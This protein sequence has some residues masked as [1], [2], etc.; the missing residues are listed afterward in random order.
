MLKYGVGIDKVETFVCES[1]QIAVGRMVQIGMRQFRKPHTPLAHHLTGYIDSMDFAAIPGEMGDQA[2]DPAANFQKAEFAFRLPRWKPRHV[3]ANALN[4]IFR[5]P[6]EGIF[7]LTVVP[8]SNIEPGVFLRP[9][10]PVVLHALL[11][12]AD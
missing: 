6:D 10:V 12:S 2:S 1:A 5:M 4:D 3:T 8:A 9:M 7:A 11:E